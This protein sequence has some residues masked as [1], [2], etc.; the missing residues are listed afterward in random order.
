MTMTDERAAAVVGLIAAILEVDTS[1]ITDGVDF[2]QDLDADSLQ[3]AELAAA[4]ESDYGVAVD[5]T[6]PP[7]NLGQ[8]LAIVGAGP[9]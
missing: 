3:L 1:E 4:L 7:V 6:D 5:A 8:V 9:A 2:Q